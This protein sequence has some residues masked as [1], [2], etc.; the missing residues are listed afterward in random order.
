MPD[1]TLLDDAHRA[2]SARPDDPAARLAYYHRLAASELCLLLEE[3]PEGNALAPR[4]LDLSDGPIVLAFDGEERLADFADGPVPYAA[5]P[6]R[7]IVAQ[8]A[9]QGIGLGINLGDEGHAFLMPATA[10]DWLAGVLAQAPMPA[11]AR[12]TGWAAPAEPSLAAVLSDRLAGL[13]AL[14]AQG[15]LAGA[16]GDD[17]QPMQILVLQDPAERA[18]DALAKAAAEALAFSAADPAAHSVLF[19]SGTECRAL[20]LPLLAAPVTL[21]RPAAPPEPAAPQA[22]GS[23][24]DRPPR[25]R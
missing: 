4:I 14:A 13:G 16:L 19:L 8:L 21:S 12:P 9:G 22:P 18:E 25:L 2:L 1:M 17:G 3:E 23:D 11:P 15:W 6:G 24:P 10:V 7:V 20:G 5:L